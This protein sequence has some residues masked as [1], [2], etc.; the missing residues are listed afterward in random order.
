MIDKSE[1]GISAR[2]IAIQFDC[3]KTQIQNVLKNKDFIRKQWENGY[4]GDRKYL[5]ARR[6]Q[7][8][9]LNEKV[10]DWFCE[11]RSKIFQLRGK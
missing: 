9:D 10:W 8:S 4:A 3:G 2:Q 6:T 7:Y 11:I 1:R 5:V